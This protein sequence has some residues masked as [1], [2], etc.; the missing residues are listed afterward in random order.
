[1]AAA[2]P[3]DAHPHVNASCAQV[4]G[5]HDP[6]PH[7]L[8]PPPPHVLPTGHAPHSATPSHPSGRLP[9]LA[10]SSAQLR[11]RQPHRLGSPPPPQ[12]LGT[13]QPPQSST[14]AQPSDASPQDAPTSAQ[15]I[16]THDP[17]PHRLGPAAPH[18]L[19]AG[20]SPHW[21]VPPHPSRALPQLTPRSAHVRG[22]H[23]LSVGASKASVTEVS[24]PAS[25]GGPPSCGVVDSAWPQP[26]K[27]AGITHARRGRH[28]REL[29]TEVHMHVRRDMISKGREDNGLNDDSTGF[30]PQF[31]DMIGESTARGEK[32]KIRG[33]QNRWMASRYGG[34]AR[35]WEGANVRTRCGNQRAPSKLSPWDA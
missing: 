25:K 35:R 24:S 13:G 21:T 20:Q 28:Q 1:M 34:R 11:G 33:R 10:P 6:S 9:Q 5:V 14:S 32:R 3:S 19:P 12:V 30:L 26:T 7:R 4:L 23:A 16:A 15:D 17:S 27:A 29:R 2:H 22:M 18:V 8:G 31:K